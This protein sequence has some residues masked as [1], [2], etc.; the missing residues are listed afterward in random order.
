MS[1]VWVLCT[2]LWWLSCNCCRH[3]GRWGWPSAQP[4]TMICLAYCERAGQ[5]LL[6][7][8]LRGLDAAVMGLLVGGAGTQSSCLRLSSATDAGIPKGRACNLHGQLIGLATATAHVLICGTIFPAPQGRSHFG[9]AP[10]GAT[11][12]VWG[13]QEPLWRDVY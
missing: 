9:V 5:S 7:T 11:C 2:L 13:V 10:A 6:P 3:T 4:A 1:P 12:Q 8:P